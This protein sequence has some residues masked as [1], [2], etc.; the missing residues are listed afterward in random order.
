MIPKFPAL[1]I[2]SLYLHWFILD[3]ISL[4]CFH[5]PF[6]SHQDAFLLESLTNNLNSDRE[7]MHFISAIVLISPFSHTVQLL[8]PKCSRQLVEIFIYTSYRNDTATII[9]L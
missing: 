4:Q 6:H 7:T 3:T 5:Y 2:I 1:A 9:K 8:V